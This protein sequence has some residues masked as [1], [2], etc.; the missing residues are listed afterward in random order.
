MAP[1]PLMQHPL[2]VWY[3]TTQLWLPA[4]HPPANN[5]N[6]QAIDQVLFL[7]LFPL[8]MS[9]FCLFGALCHSEHAE[10]SK[11]ASFFQPGRRC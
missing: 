9:S 10:A 8:T 3:S 5:T 7:L 2:L 4:R 11:L 1:L 6:V